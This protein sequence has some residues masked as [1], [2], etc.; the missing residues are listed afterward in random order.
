MFE[1][2]ETKWG[3]TLQALHQHP[4]PA[5]S[6]WCCTLCSLSNTGRKW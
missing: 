6:M 1:I 2:N 5:A 4:D 3:M